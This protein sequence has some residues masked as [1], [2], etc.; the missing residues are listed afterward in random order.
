LEEKENKTNAEEKPFQNS[1]C[2]KSSSMPV[3]VKTAS[4]P[5]EESVNA[6][7]NVMQGEA[8]VLV[9]PISNANNKKESSEGPKI[10]PKSILH[11]ISHDDAA[12]ALDLLIHTNTINEFNLSSRKSSK[13]VKFHPEVKLSKGKEIAFDKEIKTKPSTE[14]DQN[15]GKPDSKNPENCRNN[16]LDTQ[17]K[18]TNITKSKGDISYYEPYV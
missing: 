14:K 16:T 18:Y 3:E 5:L 12:Q 2:E 7:S 4:T 1:K 17:K 10:V 15:D 11:T 9:S 13:R 6:N 8:K